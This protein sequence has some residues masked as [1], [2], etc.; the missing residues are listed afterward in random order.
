MGLGVVLQLR[1]L[2]SQSKHKLY[3]G[4]LPRDYTKESLE[5]DLKKHVKGAAVPFCNSVLL[6]RK[7]IH[8]ACAP[9]LH[10]NGS[11][12]LLKVPWNLSGLCQ[13]QGRTTSRSAGIVKVE[14]HTRTQ[15]LLRAVT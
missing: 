8:P 6:S 9:L 15:H 13:K 7:H 5:A 4:K 11:F 1:V 2:P 3:I 10:R 14:C 12:F